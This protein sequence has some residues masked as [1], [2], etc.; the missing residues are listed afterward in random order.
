M[1]LRLAISWI[2]RSIAILVIL[3]L[4]MGIFFVLPIQPKSNDVSILGYTFSIKAA[5]ALGLDWREAYRAALLDLKPDRIRLPIYWDLLEVKEGSYDWSA[6][7]EQLSLLEGTE[8]DVILSIGHKLPRWPECHLPRWLDPSDKEASQEALM[9][10]M[11]AV[12]VRYRSNAR[13]VS[14]QVENE[15]L[16][17][18]GDCPAW[19]SDRGMLKREIELV[20]RLD[21]QRDILTSDSGELSL[22][23]RTASLPVDGLAISLYRVVYD[24]Q[25]R[26]WPVNPYFYLWRVNVWNALTLDQVIISE[27]QAE[28]WGPT[29]VQ[30]LSLEEAYLSFSPQNLGERV[31]FARRTGAD[32][33]LAWGVE[34]WYYMHKNKLDVDYWKEAIRTFNP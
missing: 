20:R 22:W 24:T 34:W 5:E 10:M 8:T 2:L 14:W 16:F 31:D 11:E 29:P 19:S 13:L 18:F 28:P 27:L 30:H 32:T 23:L 21:P 3:L 4:V 1:S 9:A 17:P 7:D 6:F 33:V 26:Y 12:V 15:A 25:Y